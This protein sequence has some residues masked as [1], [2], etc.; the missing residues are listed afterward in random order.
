MCDVEIAPEDH[1]LQLRGDLNQYHESE[2]FSE[3]ET[4][5]QLVR[6]NVEVTLAK[7]NS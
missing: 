5:G 2:A 1:V 3:C 4:M 6:K 7:T